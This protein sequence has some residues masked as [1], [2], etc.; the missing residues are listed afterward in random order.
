[1]KVWFFGCQK[2]TGDRKSIKDAEEFSKMSLVK[3]GGSDMKTKLCRYALRKVSKEFRV[4][5]NDIG[6]DQH[7]SRYG[8]NFATHSY[9]IEDIGHLCVMTM[10]AFWG[11]MTMETVVISPVER[12]LPLFNIDRVSAFGKETLLIEIYDTQI[13][14]LDADIQESFHA[15][16]E[17]DSAVSDVESKPHWYDEIRYPFSY[18]KAGK[19]LSQQFERAQKDYLGTFLQALKNAPT[20]DREA[21]LEK[22]REFA[23]K[24][25][26]NDGPAVNTM[27]SLFGEETMKRVVLGH[28]YGVG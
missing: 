17:R 8:M 7:L 19:G 28:M 15:L 12:D 18:G 5:E 21:K 25:V 26:E 4:T 24:L 20:C 1:M 9:E 27:R 23:E 6:P 3:H 11:L 14:P 16:L 13:E 10:K 22:N 2:E